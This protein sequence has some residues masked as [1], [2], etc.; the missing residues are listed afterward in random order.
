MKMSKYDRQPGLS[1][2][3]AIGGSQAPRFDLR[4]LVVPAAALGLC[5]VLLWAAQDLSTRFDYHSVV[6][7]M[8]HVPARLLLEAL[9]ATGL[10]YVALVRRDV[11]ALRYLGAAVPR[12]TIWVGAFAGSALGNAV[13]FGT[14]TG[15]AVRYRVFGAGGARPGQIAQLMI[16]TGATFALGLI[17]FG[18]LGL[19]MT[20][21]G[22]HRVTGLSAPLLGSIGAAALAVSVAAIVLCRP[23]RPPLRLRRF[24]L[25]WPAR[26]F[27][28]TQLALVGIDVLGAGL[29]LWVLLPATGIGFG[30]FMAIYTAAL[31]LGVI[32]HTPGGIGVFEAAIVLVLGHSAPA[33]AIVAA[34]LLYRAVYFILPLLLATALLAGLEMRGLL[35]RLAPRAAEA[36]ARGP[37]LLPMFLAVITFVIGMMLVISGATPAFG[38]RLA[39]LAQIV[40][41]WLLESSH[42][43]GSLA[44]VLLLFVARGL[45]FRLDAAWWLALALAV[46]GLAVSLA[47]GLAFIEAGVLGFLILM[48]LLTRP[49]FNRQASLFARPLSPGALASVAIVLSVAFWVLFF[50]FRHVP[51]SNDLWW[52][53]EFDDKASRALRGTVAA[54]LLAAG[55]ALW[56]MLRLAPGRAA[57]PTPAD[58]HEA[59]QIV[60]GQDRSDA[61]L[62]MMGDKSFLFSDARHTFLMYAKH[63]RNWVALHDPVGPRE[64]WP[65]LITRFIAV[66]QAH[67][68]RAAFYQVRSDALPFYLEAGLTLVKLGEEARITLADFRLEGARMSHLRYALKRGARDG[69]TAEVFDAAGVGAILPVLKGVS[70]AWLGSRRAGEKGFSVAAFDPGYLARQSVM[71]VCQSGRPVAFATFMTTDLRTDATVGV[72]RHVPDA[73]SYAMEFLFTQLA[74]HLRSAGFQCLSLGMAPL[75][76]LA[77]GTLASFWHRIGHLLWSYGNRLYSFRGLRSFKSKFHP[78]WEPRYL[79]TS[80]MLGPILTL[81]AVAAVGHDSEP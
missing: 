45:F 46:I 24:V 15:G 54:T 28:L 9:L 26:R 43:I 64:E 52:Q 57:Q 32:G 40:P 47:Q 23:D 79:A 25:E 81:A 34:L 39:V 61:M 55:I 1:P 67:A 18:G 59:E 21:P 19:L 6:R 70:D 3:A 38:G 27:V 12:S 72:M 53:F 63:G 10:S 16:L 65:E 77:P 42:L 13:G 41:L 4:R 75:S 66:A 80:G 69:L 60:R 68:G 74:L 29:C 56:Q 31:L 14:L 73:S 20:A 7:A 37:Q 33:G 76:G 2:E 5:A 78:V 36:V 35:A 51:Y 62:A 44:G 17:A 71:L 30:G 11:V 49:R 8:R 50:A 22:L 58:L 48:L